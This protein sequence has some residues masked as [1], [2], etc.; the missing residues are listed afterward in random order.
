MKASTTKLDKDGGDIN[1]TTLGHNLGFYLDK[2]KS[3]HIDNNTKLLLLLY[4]RFQL[5]LLHRL[6]LL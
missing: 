3:R 5:K 6:L 2:E 4:I 1:T